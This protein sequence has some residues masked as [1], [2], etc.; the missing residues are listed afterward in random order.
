MVHI[1]K[2]KLL[3]KPKLIKKKLF[4]EFMWRGKSGTKKEKREEARNTSTT[5]LG[6]VIP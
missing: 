4:H 2:K 1:K 3:R 6:L 5:V